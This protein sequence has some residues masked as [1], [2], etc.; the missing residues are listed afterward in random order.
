MLLLFPPQIT[1]YPSRNTTSFQRLYDV[2]CLLGCKSYN[3][4]PVRL[5]KFIR[6]CLTAFRPENLEH[7]SNSEDCTVKICQG[8]GFL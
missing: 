7:A 4:V 8:K 3:L 1:F 2:V 5:I 6:N